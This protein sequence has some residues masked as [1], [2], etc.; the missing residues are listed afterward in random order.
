M[1]CNLSTRFLEFFEFKSRKYH[2]QWQHVR[3]NMF[4]AISCFMGLFFFKNAQAQNVDV[5]PTTSKIGETDRTGYAVCIELDRKSVTNFWQKTLKD[6]K[7][8]VI[9]NKGNVYHALNAQPSQFFHKSVNLSS[10]VEQTGNCMVVFVSGRDETEKPLEGSDAENLKKFLYEFGVQIY[11]SDVGDQITQAEKVVDLSVKAQEKKV[12]EGNNL[13]NKLE[14]SYK[15]RKKLIQ[16]LEDNTIN[17][18]KLK[19]DSIRNVAEQDQALEEIKKVRE[20][21]EQK[22]SKLNQIK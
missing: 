10:K 21:L 3:L 6:T 14:R 20:V 18:R 4:F 15:E 12:S 9:S 17:T 7:G 8:K 1:N 13:K 11:R 22:K 19:Q 16:N 5:R 2:F